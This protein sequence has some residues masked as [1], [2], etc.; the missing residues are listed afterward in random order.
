MRLISRLTGKGTG[1]ITLNRHG[2]HIDH[3]PEEATVRAIV[4]LPGVNEPVEI[5]RCIA[6]PNI[7]EC[8]EGTRQHV[9]PIM[10]LAGRGQHLLT[11]RDILKYI[12]AEASTRAQ[13]IQDLLNITEIE[14]IR[15][16]L[17]KV[18]NDLDRECQEAKRSVDTAKEAVNATVQK[19][20]FGEDIVLQIVNQNRALLGGQPIL[21]LRSTA[22]KTGL[23][24]PTVISSGQAI[25]ITLLE[26]D[27]Q[28]LRN[29]TLVENQAQ[30]AKSDEELRALTET[31]RSDSQ[32]LRA[33]SLLELTKLGMTL[34]D[35]TG[36][37]PLCDTP[38]PLG[39]LRAY[40]E[41]RIS[42]AQ[43]AVQHQK[44]I[45]ELS[46]TIAGS[47]DKTIASIQQV[48]EA[49]EIAD[50][51]D[52]LPLLQ[53]WLRSLVGLSSALRA[54][55]EKYPDPCFSPDQVQRI[56][57]PDN[58]IELLD[59]IHSTVSAK[60]P[61]ATPEQTAWDTLTRLEEN[62]KAIEKAWRVSEKPGILF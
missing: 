59:R 1:G 22:L 21:T 55:I 28:N 50:L 5:K 17:V 24:P 14:E 43:A 13:E 49:T 30:I 15:K 7:L 26:K 25:N 23:I 42:T 2:A 12:T 51:K 36:G 46:A 27:I 39:E 31:I 6:H 57:A 10:T 62:F 45:V 54:V 35:E 16:A 8:D 61:P 58:V 20:T 11:R 44:R 3:K 9:E 33:L 41:E 52:Q 60:Y 48:I 19:Q 4:Q 53:S 32:L 47:V 37:C 40:L 29:V 56:L 18:R 38:W 34:I